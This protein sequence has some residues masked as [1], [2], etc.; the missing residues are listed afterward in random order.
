MII[1]FL[2][3]GPL[4]WPSFRFSIAWF[5][6]AWL[7][8]WLTGWSD[9]RPSNKQKIITWILHQFIRVR[10]ILLYTCLVTHSTLFFSGEV[11]NGFVGDTQSLTGS[12]K[13]LSLQPVMMMPHPPPSNGP[14]P[15]MILPDEYSEF[16]PRRYDYWLKT[17][18]NFG[19]VS[20]FSRNPYATNI[21][22]FQL[23]R[24]W[25]TLNNDMYCKFVLLM[26]L[27]SLLVTF[28]VYIVDLEINVSVSIVICQSW[29]RAASLGQNNRLPPLSWIQDLT[30]IWRRTERGWSTPVSS[31]RSC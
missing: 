17:C 18:R 11:N 6:A 3:G 30:V 16:G 26:C 5:W 27:D 9:C 13:S 22:N 14:P 1:L 21:Q 19:R 8:P 28:W 10:K 15:G 29:S 2:L 7:L 20:D 12:R 23:W 31:N 24:A 25:K 4:F